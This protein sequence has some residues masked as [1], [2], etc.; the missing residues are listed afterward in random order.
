MLLDNSDRMFS[1][2]EESGHNNEKVNF[3]IDLDNNDKSVTDDKKEKTEEIV[4]QQISDIEKL[5]KDEF[6]LKQLKKR[7]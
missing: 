7:K 4:T 2:A 3:R 6:K 5:K 1:K